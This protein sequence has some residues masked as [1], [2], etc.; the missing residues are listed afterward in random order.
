MP[1]ICPTCVSHHCLRAAHCHTRNGMQKAFLYHIRLFGTVGYARRG[2]RAHQ[3]APEGETCIMLGLP[4]N[5]PR[6]TVKVFIVR[7]GE[8]VHR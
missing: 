2:E 6:D 5:H 8:V 4:H 1:T 7:S 3:L